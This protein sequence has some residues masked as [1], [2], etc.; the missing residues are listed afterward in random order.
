MATSDFSSRKTGR[1]AIAT[2]VAGI[3]AL[4]FLMLLVWIVELG[5]IN[6]VFNSVMGILSGIL[7]WMLHPEHH[8]RSRLLSQ[9]ALILA[10]VGA[11]IVVA[12]SVLVIS[13][14]TGFVLAGWYSGIGYALIG[15]WLAAF[16]FSMRGG[17]TLPRNLVT[18]GLIA[19]VVMALGLLDISGILAGIDSMESLTGILY[20]GYL[21]FLGVYILYPIW[22]IRLGRTLLSQ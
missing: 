10:V 18:F 22:T 3:V 1:I 16:C 11:L 9:V 13:G 2:G 12:G 8:S 21:G 15:L 6:D 7:A 19:G 14:T 4:V 20:V 17:N 5:I